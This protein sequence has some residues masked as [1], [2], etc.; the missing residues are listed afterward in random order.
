MIY[1]VVGQSSAIHSTQR[2]TTLKLKICFKI[3]IKKPSESYASETTHWKLIF[4]YKLV[5]CFFI[6]VA[7][8]TLSII[9]DPPISLD[10]YL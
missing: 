4:K 5:L 7:I 2:V 3:I 10:P 1:S 6:S 8:S 9:L